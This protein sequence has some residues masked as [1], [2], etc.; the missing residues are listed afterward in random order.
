M[1]KCIFEKC[2]HKT[3]KKNKFPNIKLHP[4]PKDLENI[5]AWLS[6]GD[7]TDEILR[8]SA[9]AISRDKK[10]DRF[11]MCS[12]HFSEESFYMKKTKL[13][14][15]QIAVPTVFPQDRSM[16]LPKKLTGMP[17]TEASN[18]ICSENVIPTPSPSTCPIEQSL[19]CCS[20]HDSPSAIIPNKCDFA[21]QT[22]EDDFMFSLS[23]K[24]YVFGASYKDISKDHDYAV[25]SH[26][27][28]PQTLISTPVK[29]SL[30]QDRHQLPVNKIR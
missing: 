3:G 25:Y 27:V 13:V 19:C 16:S 12:A 20:C 4:F 21:T 5:K 2:P 22:C 23:E 7:L 18:V 30:A 14:L 10:G 17:D 15:K 8:E 1:P 28:L 11:R 29:I 9:Q 26:L 6:C 24:S